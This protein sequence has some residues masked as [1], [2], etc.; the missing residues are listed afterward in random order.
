MKEY[1]V[2]DLRSKTF[3]CFP[4]C[5]CIFLIIFCSVIFT[6]ARDDIRFKNFT[7]NVEKHAL[8]NLAQWKKGEILKGEK[9]IGEFESRENNLGILA[10]R[11]G[12]SYGGKNTE[13]IDFRLKEKN[14]DEWYY[15]NLYHADQFLPDEL[16][17]FGFPVIPNSSGKTYIFEIESLNGKPGNAITISAFNPVFET[18]YKYSKAE[19][20][21]DPGLLFNYLIL[22]FSHYINLTEL[23]LIIFLSII[24]MI[25]VFIL[26]RFERFGLMLNRYIETIRK[27]KHLYLLLPFIIF[28][29]TF[30]VSGL[31][32]FISVDPHHDGIMLK[33]ALDVV[34]GKVLFRDTFTQ[35]GALTTYIQA[36]A[37]KIFGN[38]LIVIKLFT[39]LFYALSSVVLWFIWVR[40][41]PRYLAT[42]SCFML[43]LLGTYL[44]WIVIPWSSVYSLFFQTLSLYIFIKS[45]ES[46]QGKQ[47]YLFL[48][49]VAVAL[50]FWCR[51]PVGIFLFLAY[52]GYFAL[53]TIK[54]KFQSIS[55]ILKNLAYFISGTVIIHFSFIIWLIS[56]RALNDWF[57]QSVILPYQFGQRVGKGYLSLEIL[58]DLFPTFMDF[59]W[60]LIPII[61]IIFFIWTIYHFLKERKTNSKRELLLVII[62]VSL[63]SWTQYYP[64]VCE[65]HVYWAAYP[66]IGVTVYVFYA[67]SMRMCNF[68]NKNNLHNNHTIIDSYVR[69]I[70][71]LSM[72]FSVFSPVIIKRIQWGVMR[73]NDNYLTVNDLSVLKLIRL[74]PIDKVFY[75][76][77]YNQ[78]RN[79]LNKHPDASI[80]TNGPDALYL[81]FYNQPNN[82]HPIYINWDDTKNVYPNYTSTLNSY[83]QKSNPVIIG[84]SFDLY[85]GY[86]QSDISLNARDVSIKYPYEGDND[87]MIVDLDRNRY[88][89]INIRIDKGEKKIN[90]IF[91]EE[92]NL[93]DKVRSW[94]MI[95]KEYYGSMI[96]TRSGWQNNLI[97]IE[98]PDILNYKTRVNIKVLFEGDECYLEKELPV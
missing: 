6:N 71:L 36:G 74:F 64:V 82:F 58:N 37:L 15:D 60:V 69:I 33:P 26:D 83:I 86:C 44:I 61:C 12:N 62:L 18:K 65:W 95:K 42:L 55:S 93:E 97:H 87:F 54:N 92:R 38:Y 96:V 7:I 10:F 47:K 46:K 25:L 76:N 59:L 49:G 52:L 24:P 90:D 57:L 67:L 50:T 40:I 84:N 2:L 72:F 77:I 19:L 32:S 28:I 20:F 68:N 30:L 4:I 3:F 81:T 53:K 94:R 41:M 35:Y 31:F 1:K 13:L 16:F 22:K 11:F 73:L 14:T 51:Q 56:N 27:I 29:A 8:T 91:V 89:G 39:A 43:I 34:S 23:I 80:I 5:F 75:E 70:I 66:M 17:T 21:H 85:N 48:S 45:I 9:I 98:L 88:T 78:L 63:A 79:Y